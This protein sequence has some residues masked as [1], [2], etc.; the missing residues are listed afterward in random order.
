MDRKNG[1]MASVGWTLFWVIIIIIAI[2][3]FLWFLLTLAREDEPLA[4]I[5]GDVGQSCNTNDD[6]RSNLVC[7]QDT[8]TCK[9][10]QGQA[11]TSN[12]QCLTGQVCNITCTP[13]LLQG[14][15]NEPCLPN[16]V[17]QTGL[18]CTNNICKI[19]VGGG[20]LTNNDCVPGSICSS[21]IC[22]IS[23]GQVC[24]TNNQCAENLRCIDGTCSQ[25]AALNQP[26]ND[27]IKCFPEN[28][29]TCV[30]SIGNSMLCKLK[31]GIPCSN[32]S[33]CSSGTCSNNMCTTVGNT[34]ISCNTGANC[35]QNICHPSAV[36]GLNSDGS[37][38]AT[39]I[40]SNSQIL[41]IVAEGPNR[42]V[43][44]SDGNIIRYMDNRSEM[45]K[46]NVQLQQLAFL[47]SVE[48]GDLQLFGLSG[49]TV[50]QLD[51]QNSTPT[52]WKWQVASF[53]PS[54]V[55]HISNSHDGQTL[56]IQAMVGNRQI[57][58]LYTSTNKEIV[59]INETV[60]SADTKRVY[61]PNGTTFIESSLSDSTSRALVQPQGL[62][63]TDYHRGIILTDGRTAHIST[64]L[65]TS[66][67]EIKMVNGVPHIIVGRVCTEG[68]DTA[69]V[70]ATNIMLS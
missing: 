1:A 61:G 20:C 6:C 44:L 39:N 9:F 16:N 24:T 57:G 21:D 46:N 40:S 58:R 4:T 3:I 15:L 27:T 23:E 32:N 8:K 49:T 13:S 31:A 68:G 52:H 35:P 41:D 36:F 12:E 26:C 60:L 29:L 2:C 65:R 47:G 34:L 38:F 48:G 28:D 7:D 42:I 55:T 14:A 56:W 64:K 69:N 19:P 33:N 53:A 63:L 30:A 59:L 11:C 70:L 67:T 22:K 18:I 17:C 25:F 51:V 45:I 10:P 50:Y 5:K 54:N 37:V 62:L 43:L 66:V